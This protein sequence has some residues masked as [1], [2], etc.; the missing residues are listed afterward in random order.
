MR[1][2]ELICH[3]FGLEDLTLKYD[4]MHVYARTHYTY[5]MHE[6]YG[7]SKA[8]IARLSGMEWER[9]HYIL[10]HSLPSWQQVE[11][12][13]FDQHFFFTKI[14]QSWKTAS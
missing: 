13:H 14:N 2:T 3:R 5:I 10:Q 7:Y 11:K 4:T 1:L 9:I 8:E 12:W 6:V